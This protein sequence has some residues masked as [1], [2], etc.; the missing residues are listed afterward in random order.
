MADAG[1]IQSHPWVFGDATLALAPLHL[2]P[3]ASARRRREPLSCGLF[4][5]GFGLLALANFPA[6]LEPF[7]AWASRT[8]PLAIAGSILAWLRTPHHAVAVARPW[9]WRIVAPV[10]L[11]AWGALAPGRVPVGPS[12]SRSPPS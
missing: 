3:F 10:A 12:C 9:F 11:G 4:V 8:F 7:S 6:I 1:A 2:A 5:A